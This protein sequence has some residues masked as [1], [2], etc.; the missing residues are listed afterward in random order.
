MTMTRTIIT[1]SREEGSGGR[2]IAQE[3]ARKLKF[4]YIDKQLI[5][6]ATHR[7]GL[8]QEELTRFDE[9]ILPHL[10]QLQTWLTQPPEL[11]LSSVLVPDRDAYGLIIEKPELT[12]VSTTAQEVAEL[13]RQ[14]ILQG[15]HK[16]IEWLV[17]EVA[18]QH[19]A[20]IVGRGANF[21]LKNRPGV[22]NLHFTAPITERVER[23][24]YLHQ[25]NQAEAAW[26]IAEQ[27]ENRSRYI[28]HYYAADWRSPEH[29]H[30]VVNTSQLSLPNIT[31]ALISYIKEMEKTWQGKKADPVSIHRSYDRLMQ[32]ESYT[33]NEAAELLM[34]GPDVLRH[35]VYR[36]ELKGQLL[37]HQVVRISREALLEWI[38]LFYKVTPLANT[39][40]PVKTS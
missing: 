11:S 20:V 26:W 5:A 15:Y 14:Q 29:Y 32:Q 33:L 2:E 3:L 25:I 7:L 10:P 8:S 35:A 28:R 40:K 38:R 23:I 24:A 36:G 22:I 30:L 12:S 21:I 6:M 31:T 37:N 16:L 39:E 4:S 13:K 17:K 19:S 9:K 18:E 1:V 34:M 27:D